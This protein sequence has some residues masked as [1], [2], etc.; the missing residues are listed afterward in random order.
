MSPNPHSKTN[1]SD[2]PE[3]KEYRQRIDQVRQF[4][5]SC[6]YE[7]EHSE[8]AARLAVQMFDQLRSEFQLSGEDRFLLEC[9]AVLHDIGWMEGQQKHHKTTFRMILQDAAMPLDP[10]QRRITALIARYHRK[11]LPRPDHPVYADL[12]EKDRRR[13][14]ILG[15][16]LRIADGLDR[17]HMDAVR[18]VEAEITDRKL[19][20]RCRSRGPALPEMEEAREKSA[21]LQRAAEREIEIIADS[22]T[23]PDE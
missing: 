15:G 23:M 22:S 1:S 13:V 9:A 10:S 19:I 6:R 2:D 21:L 11:A 14:E 8:Q 3:A 7:K 12:A 4:A 18:G 16:I 20:L 17:T 5:A